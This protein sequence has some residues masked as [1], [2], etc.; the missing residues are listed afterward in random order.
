[1]GRGNT[2]YTHQVGGDAGG[3]H[4]G[5][6]LNPTGGKLDRKMRMIPDF[7]TK[8]RVEEEEDRNLD[9][10]DTLT[11]PENDCIATYKLTF[12]KGVFL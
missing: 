3:T 7:K 6:Q 1:M 2:S 4:Q 8:P 5:R 11:C 12:L 9:R 10:A